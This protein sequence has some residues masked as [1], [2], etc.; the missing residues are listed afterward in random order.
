[1]AKLTISQLE[2]HLLKAADI[3]RGRMDASE[4][5]EYIFG[6][7]FLKRLSDQFEIEQQKIREKWTKEGFS[8]REVEELV[9]DPGQYGGGFFVPKEARWISNQKDSEGLLYLKTDVGNQLNIAMEKLEEFNTELVGVLKDINFLAKKGNSRKTPDTKLVDLITHF[10]KINLRNDNFVFPDLL[11]SAYEYMIKDF[12]DSAGKKGGEF[13]TPSQVVR[14]MVHLI[15]PQEGNEIYDPTC[16]SGGM[17]IQSKQ[18]VIEQGQ[19]ANRIALYGQDN[20]GTVWSICKMN[21]ILHNIPDA[22]VENEDTLEKPQFKKDGYIKQFDRVIANPPFSQNYSKSKMEY[23]NRFKYGFCPETGKKADLMFVQ[24][25]IASLKKNGMM[26]TVM[27]HGV[28]FRG[29]KE[30]EIRQGMVDDNI[31]EA[32]IGLPQ[33]LFYGTGIPACILIVN[34]SKPER[35]KDQILFINADAE[36]GEARNQNYLRPEDIEKIVYVFDKKKDE[37]RYSKLVKKEDIIKEDYNLNIRRYVDNTPDPEI[38]DVRGHMVGGIPIREVALLRPVFERY[39]IAESELFCDREPGY[40]DF[41]PAIETKACINDM[42]L[43]HPKVIE[44][45]QLMHVALEDFW[46]TVSAHLP[47]LSSESGL[48]EFRRRYIS[49]LRDKLTEF[50]ILNEFQASGV[51]VNWWEHSYLIRE[52]EEEIDDK[53]VKLKEIMHVET[54]LKTII[55][56][57]YIQNLIP[58]QLIIER[59]L[60]DHTAAINEMEEK[61]SDLE[62]KLTE[63]AANVDIELELTE[64]EE[65]EPEKTPKNVKA[66]LKSLIKDLESSASPSTVK[67]I[68]RLKIIQK[69]ISNIEKELRVVKKEYKQRVKAL[70]ALIEEQREKFIPA[71]CQ[72]LIHD[73]L[74][75]LIK[76]DLNKYLKDE[77]NKVTAVFENLWDKYTVTAY[78]LVKERDQTSDVLN[79]FLKKL[80]YV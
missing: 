11:G 63:Y 75:N 55:S 66:A 8:N 38:E 6:M 49:I 52:Y 23:T 46:E 65:E 50:G 16:G 1:M 64:G 34:K 73:T 72:T 60:S 71:V 25:M 17:L 53:T 12:A 74:Y 2:N 69:D 35:L 62:G 44:K 31:I 43:N 77:I 68:E 13:Y 27:P 19:N 79:N 41:L 26:A 59:Y 45:E 51:F 58:N 5:K 4:Y 61:V 78:Q 57:G 30:K 76:D 54:A 39:G 29:G 80:R 36:Y 28:L 47:K 37:R 15:R 22:H 20:N 33:N 67:E 24:H 21:M 56:Q 32:I 42:I 48:A 9:E 3:L 14:L 70:E 10:N 18:Y 40:Y 7:L